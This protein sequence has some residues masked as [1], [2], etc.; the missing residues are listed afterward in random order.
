M[1][2]ANRRRFGRV[3]ARFWRRGRMPVGMT[4]CY[5][6]RFP[7]LYRALAKAGARC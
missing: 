5:D 7:Y 6:L 1:V 3:T 2:I 4:V